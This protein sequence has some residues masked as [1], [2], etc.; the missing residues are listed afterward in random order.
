MDAHEYEKAVRSG[1]LTLDQDPCNE[2]A[3]NSL[4]EAYGRLG[5]RE[6]AIMSYRKYA[7][8]IQD[9]LGE[10]PSQQVSS[11]YQAVLKGR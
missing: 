5:N 6:A 4:I 9:E 1:R 7:S 10:T 11:R 2:E 8:R 3:V